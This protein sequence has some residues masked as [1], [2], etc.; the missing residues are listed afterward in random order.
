MTDAVAGIDDENYVDAHVTA[1]APASNF[2]LG[3]QRRW[4][5]GWI[6]VDSIVVQ[7]VSRP[8]ST[9]A[10]IQAN[11]VATSVHPPVGVDFVMEKLE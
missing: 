7:L 5:W 6:A 11:V 2:R 9:Y 1:W 8:A 3:K 10:S 4:G